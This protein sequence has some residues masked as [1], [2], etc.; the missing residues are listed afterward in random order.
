MTD[1]L[2]RIEHKVDRLHEKLDAYSE[3]LVK[4]ES[5][6]GWIKYGLTFVISLFSALATAVIKWTH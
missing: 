5:S 6:V 2:E 1:P 4:T 3:R